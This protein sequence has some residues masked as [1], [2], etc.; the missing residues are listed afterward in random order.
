MNFRGVGIII[1]NN[2]VYIPST[3]TCY[4][5]III[6]V[7][8]VYNIGFDV[9]E[10]VEAIRKVLS[11]LD[12]QTRIPDP[13]RDEW[14]NRKD[15]VLLATKAKNWKALAKNGHSYGI[16]WLE[17]NI[18]LTFSRLDKKGRWEIDSEKTKT[19]PLNTST[20]DIVNTILDDLKK[21][22]KDKP[23]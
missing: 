21:N 10:I 13:T 1:W 8:P 16:E 20:D 14:K 4:S 15:P 18:S 17:Q 23:N 11:S 9:A 2:R 19:Y 6:Q 7:E 22:Q 3:A 12:N 5:G